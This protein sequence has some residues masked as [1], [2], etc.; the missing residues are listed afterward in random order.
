M[1]TGK[2]A[3]ALISQI[4]RRSSWTIAGQAGDRTS[5][6][7]QQL[8]NWTVWDTAAAMLV[9]RRFA[10]ARLDQAARIGGPRGLGSARSMRPARS[11][12]A[13]ARPG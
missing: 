3:A 11:S 6:K 2:Y 9:V 5:D 1:Q 7:T 8:V 10:V 13:G 12:R 4:L